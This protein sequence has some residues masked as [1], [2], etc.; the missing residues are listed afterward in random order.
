MSLRF[1]SSEDRESLGLLTDHIIANVDGLAEWICKN[2]GDE[3]CQCMRA[4]SVHTEYGKGI[5]MT[6]EGC[7]GEHTVCVQPPSKRFDRRT[8][9]EL[10][11]KLVLASNEGV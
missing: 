6:F 1:D 4:V 2:N 9:E 10:A 8:P 5:W 7:R 3:D 11:G